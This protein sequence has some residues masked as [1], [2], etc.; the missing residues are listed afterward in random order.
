LDSQGQRQGQGP[1]PQGPGLEL[2]G[3]GQGLPTTATSITGS[4]GGGKGAC[5]PGGTVQ[6]AAFGGSKIWN[7]EICRFWRIGVCIADSDIFVPSQH[8]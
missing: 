2:Q 1:D 8:P 4:S 6:G 3:R 5:A 7:S